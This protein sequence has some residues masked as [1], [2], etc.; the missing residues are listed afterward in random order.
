MLKGFS[1]MRRLLPVAGVS[2]AAVLVA[3]AALFVRRR[4]RDAGVY[5]MPR[6]MFGPAVVHN[7][8]GDDGSPV[9]VLKVGGICQSATYLDDE[10]VWDLV[11]EYDKLYDRMFDADLPIRR[12][13]MI[14]G[15][16]YAYPEHL[17]AT[18]PDVLID[19]VEVD[20]AITAI[21]QRY[22]FLDR[23]IVEFETEESGRL[24]LVCED[25][26]AYL[27]AL[28]GAID[29]GADEA[30][31]GGVG[32]TG[33]GGDWPYDTQPLPYDAI[34]NDAFGGG[35]PVAALAGADAARTIRR[36]LTPGGV[37]MSNVVGALEGPGSEALTLV[38]AALA[39]AFAHVWVIPCGGDGRPAG[40]TRDAQ[41]A[42]R[43]ARSARG[44]G[45][46][47]N[48]SSADNYML[49]A[50]DIEHP[51]S[52]AIRIGGKAGGRA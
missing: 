8:E 41:P 44:R 24:G 47:S 42:G 33:A 50:S 39:E 5:I 35:T 23:L 13:L 17:V 14:G 16:G 26:R 4:L 49:V 51:F 31:A 25:G 1:N 52:D 6:T 45:V 48:N 28:A 32:G 12:A 27:D 34:L 9:R 22:F 46:S 11:F 29:G 19:V 43:G 38:A 20:P 10:R 15:G 18:R 2:A 30:G 36:C 40:E 7:V 3:G 37:Y 21:A